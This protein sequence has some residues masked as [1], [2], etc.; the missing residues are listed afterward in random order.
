MGQSVSA[1]GAPSATP[2]PPMG[3]PPPPPGPG[4]TAAPPSQQQETPVTLPEE[5]GPG[6]FEDLHKKCKGNDQ[7]D[8][9]SDR[10]RPDHQC[11]W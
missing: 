1:A 5:T 11:L 10:S 3:A 2:P 7:S 6:S 8:Q 9:I 4:V